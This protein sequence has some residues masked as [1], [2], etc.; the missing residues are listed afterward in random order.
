MVVRQDR[1][2]ELLAFLVARGEHY[3]HVAIALSGD[4]AS[5]EDLLQ[6][7]LERM[8]R[9][10]RTSDVLRDMDSYLRRALVNGAID[11]ARRRNRRPER[12]TDTVPERPYVDGTFDEVETKAWILRL[13]GTLPPQ[14]R[15]VVCLRI[16]EDMSV[17]DTAHCLGVTGGAVKSALSRALAHLRDSL[18]SQDWT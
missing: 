4:R 15:A 3:L 8:A 2:A 5:G 13:L 7:V 10:L 6:G 18:T 17:E 12:L 1:D 14:Q 11:R 16:F 9:R